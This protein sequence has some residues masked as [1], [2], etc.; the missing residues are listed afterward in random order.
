MVSSFAFLSSALKSLP[1]LSCL[2]K[3][4]RHIVVANKTTSIMFTTITAIVISSH[5]Q[6]KQTGD[7]FEHVITRIS[8]QLCV[9]SSCASRSA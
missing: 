7:E 5:S 2:L 6:R 4:L 1:K 8:L 3:K 9:F